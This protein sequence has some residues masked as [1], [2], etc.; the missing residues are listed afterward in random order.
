[1]NSLESQN[2]FSGIPDSLPDELIDTM[3][4]SHGIRIERIISDGHSSEA[5]FWYDQD[6]HEWILL[7]Q[8]EASIIYPD[9][10]EI[11]LKAGDYLL[12]PAHRKHR[13]SRTDHRQKTIWL[14]I[15]F[16]QS[17]TTE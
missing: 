15:F 9:E 4:S 13:V 11:T 12:I 10:S 14:A 7:V 1:M 2:L 3:H 8:G 5:D 6:E 17:Q 16:H